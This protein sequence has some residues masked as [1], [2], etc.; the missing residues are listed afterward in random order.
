MKFKLVE[1]G[2]PSQPAAPKKFY[3]SAVNAGKFTIK[4]VAKEIAGRSSLTKGD[5]ENVLSNFMEELPTF[6]KLGMS[7]QLGDFGTMRLNLSG[8]GAA[9]PA[10]FKT[11]TIS[12]KVIFTPSV[13][14][15]NGLADIKY[16]QANQ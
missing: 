1:K 12:A 4:D 15:K 3:P 7:V 10:A 2:N 5:I 11:D 6:L 14:L 8:E 16:E 13:E 9:T